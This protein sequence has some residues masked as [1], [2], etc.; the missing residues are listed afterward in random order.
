MKKLHALA[1]VLVGPLLYL[2]WLGAAH[3]WADHWSNHV[4][5]QN[6]KVLMDW[7]MQTDTALR[8]AGVLK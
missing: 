1:L 7:A 8:K 4:A 2:A 3:V 5:L 6:Q